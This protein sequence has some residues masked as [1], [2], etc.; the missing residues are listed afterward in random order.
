[1]PTLSMMKPLL[2]SEDAQS[3][4]VYTYTWRESEKKTKNGQDVVA[5]WR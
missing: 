2:L 5:L 3:T 4:Y 1:M